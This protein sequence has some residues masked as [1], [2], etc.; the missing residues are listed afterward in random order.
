MTLEYFIRGVLEIEQLKNWI[1][2]VTLEITGS[3]DEEIICKWCEI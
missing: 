2:P 3:F 1:R